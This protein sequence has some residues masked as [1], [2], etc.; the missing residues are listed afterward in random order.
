MSLHGPA[1]TAHGLYHLFNPFTV[2]VQAER[3]AEK[4]EAAKKA[5][6]KKSDEE[7][8]MDKAKKAEQEGKP[9]TDVLKA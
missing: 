4:A 6:A 3:E 1:G 7:K 8:E 5:E 2:L 9:A